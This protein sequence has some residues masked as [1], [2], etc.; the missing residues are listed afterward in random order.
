MRY[1]LMPADG[2]HM[3]AAQYRD[4]ILLVP[5]AA[6]SDPAA[7]PS[8]AEVV[9][10]SRKASGTGHPAVFPLAAPESV[11]EPALAKDYDENWIL[12]DQ[13]L[14]QIRRTVAGRNRR[15]WPRRAVSGPAFIDSH[16]EWSHPE[17][18]PTRNEAEPAPGSRWL[19]WRNR[20]K[21]PDCSCRK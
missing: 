17:W 20:S 2:N 21:L 19:R 10:L 5:L 1:A 11:A 15:L 12:K 7:Q 14:Y 3:G 6:D 18:G 4:F 8:F 13:D 16:P 9:T